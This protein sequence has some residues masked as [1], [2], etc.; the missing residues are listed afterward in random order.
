MELNFK[1][2]KIQA[3]QILNVLAKQPYDEVFEL[4]GTI[5]AQAN[6][7]IQNQVE[8]EEK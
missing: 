2:S 5:Q 6:N 7:Q 3:Q 1:L 8:A 4:I